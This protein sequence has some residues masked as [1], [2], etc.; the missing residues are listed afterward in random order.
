MKYLIYRVTERL[1]LMSLFG[2]PWSELSN[3]EQMDLL[4]YEVLRQQED[5]GTFKEALG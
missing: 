3:T 1:D 2:K 4:A 5:S